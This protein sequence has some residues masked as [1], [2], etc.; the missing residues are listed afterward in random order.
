MNKAFA[1]TIILGAGVVLGVAIIIGG[2]SSA[3]RAPERIGLLLR[4]RGP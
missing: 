3:Q 1:Q 2:G 4:P